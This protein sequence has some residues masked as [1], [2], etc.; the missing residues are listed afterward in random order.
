MFDFS[1]FP[2][3]TTERLI[4]REIVA[5]DAPDVL[6]FRG[7]PE[8]QRYNSEPLTDVA[9]ARAL[10]EQIH[11]W[12]TAQQSIIWGVTLREENKVL[13]FY[14]VQNWSRDHHRAEI[15]YD[16]ARSYWGQGIA[17]EAVHAMLQ[18]CFT[19]LQ[20]HRVEAHTIIDNFASVRMLEK[21]GFQ[22]EGVRREYSWEDD[23]LYHGSGTFGLLRHE[24]KVHAPD[25]K[26]T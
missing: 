8:V 10:I 12:Y 7:D 4:L 21:I 3:L 22:C 14:S 26:T 18:F 15:G 19:Q 20:L 5:D 6:I 17:T 23:G 25:G 2:I 11:E 24:Y 13:G 16:L 1:T 9:Q